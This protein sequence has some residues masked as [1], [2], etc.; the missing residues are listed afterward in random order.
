M[1][2]FSLEALQLIE[3]LSLQSKEA[4]KKLTALRA[5][6]TDS[7]AECRS[8]EAAAADK[9]SADRAAFREER[10][11][12]EEQNAIADSAVTLCVG[13]QHF[14]TSLLTLRREPSSMLGVMFSG[15]HALNRQP[16]GSVFID[17]DPTHFRF[18]LNFLRDG[19]LA[20]PQRLQTPSPAA[21][22]LRHELLMEAR[23][24]QIAS[25]VAELEGAAAARR[26]ACSAAGGS[27]KAA[28]DQVREGLSSADASQAVAAADAL[29]LDVFHPSAR[30]GF[31]PR[32]AEPPPPGC[33]FVLGERTRGWRTAHGGASSSTVPDLASFASNWEQ[34][35]LGSLA[36][37]DWSGVV[38]A[39]GAVLGCLMPMP[40][41]A[42][43][44][45]LTR[46][47]YL[48]KAM[49]VDED[50]EGTNV[51]IGGC[52]VRPGYIRLPNQYAVPGTGYGA[53]NGPRGQVHNFTSGFEDSDIDLF[54][55]G[56]SSAQ[57]I[58]KIRHI[59]AVLSA[60]WEG[61][62]IT[63]RSESAIT[64]ASYWPRRRVQVV[65]RLYRSMAEVL[66]GFD[67]D[68]CCVAYDGGRAWATRRS[69]RALNCAY[70]LV[71]PSRRSPTYELRLYKYSTRGFAV[72]VP[73]F[74][75]TKAC[76]VLGLEPKETE[77]LARLLLFAYHDRVRKDRK[78][79]FYYHDVSRMLRHMGLLG[80]GGGHES[81]SDYNPPGVDSF[82]KWV[83]SIESMREV[84]GCIDGYLKQ[85]AIIQ[86]VA[87]PTISFVAATDIEKIIRWPQGSKM[88]SF[89][90]TISLRTHVAGD[91]AFIEQDPGRQYVTGSFHP[92]D[93]DWF[94]QAYGESL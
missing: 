91:I 12:A 40:E 54:L 39:G 53:D 8:A 85:T 21:D 65:L 72:A 80:G 55:V 25:M 81:T 58:A 42:R 7:L 34:F 74:D 13:G 28:E 19:A 83:P 4:E 67:I 70:N 61:D 76:G 9:L 79:G 14:T 29:L 26:A 35:T 94:A 32:T 88:Q 6:A 30:S 78:Q 56:L 27:I 37:L 90:L 87:P 31:V 44:N 48:N 16:D 5:R 63:V 15:R 51:D 57:A 45:E 17:R 18:V 1:Q 89:D 92:D 68:A 47:L 84:E 86:P 73:A 22:A 66:L 24:Y 60:S 49:P 75:P 71:D 2:A 10:R 93:R 36:Q 52:T 46:L 41:W 3:E 64:F 59:H 82:L 50:G 62:I 11:A 43:R 33:S 38:A 20:L 77:G 69:Q 23:F